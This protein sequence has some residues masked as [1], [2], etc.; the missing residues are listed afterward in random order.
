[1][2]GIPI[3]HAERL[4]QGTRIVRLLFDLSFSVNEKLRMNAK[5]YLARFACSTSPAK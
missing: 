4:L 2:K 1:V 3:D 5:K